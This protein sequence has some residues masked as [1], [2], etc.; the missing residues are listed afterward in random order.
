MGISF[1]KRLSSY[2]FCNCMKYQIG[3]DIIVMHSNDEG[4][5]IEIINEKMV[6]IEVKGVRFPAYMDQ[7]DFPYFKRFTEKKLFPEK[8][9]VKVYVDQVPKEKRRDEVKVS[10][11]IWI[12]LFPKFETDVFGDDIVEKF[13]VYLINKT[14]LNY[15]FTYKLQY[16]G[17]SEFEITSDLLSFKDFYLHDVD[18]DNLNDSPSFDFEF[19]LLKPIKGKA[20]F[21]EATYRI[22]P[23]QLFQKIEEL[24]L[25]NLPSLN[26][27]LLDIYPDKPIAEPK[28]DMSRLTSAGYKV[29]DAAKAR[30]HL[31][32]ARSVV[33]LHIEKLR[34]NWKS[35]TNHEILSIQLKEFEK[36]YELAVLH[37]LPELIIIHG[38]G[39]GR[40]K[41]EIHD[42]LKHKDDVKSFVNRYD[43]RFGYGATEIF[44]R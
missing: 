35:M 1:C 37:H 24:K 2:Y 4:K 7:I 23:K 20:D 8:K 16:F 34:N 32:S 15:E 25:K 5:V 44:F 40:L 12:T 3:D 10:D 6:L 39:K 14:D 21:V 43:P 30:Q 41:E 27:R 13:K 11:G 29:Y 31:E 36:W 42:L 18:F 22:K 38:I 9:K 33:D 19:S 28:L 26:H 17:K